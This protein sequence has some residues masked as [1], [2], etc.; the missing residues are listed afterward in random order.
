MRTRKNRHWSAAIAM[1]V[2]LAAGCFN[3]SK[4]SLFDI[5]YLYN[6]ERDF[7]DLKCQVY[8][9]TDTTSVAFVS[10]SL[11]DLAYE[12]PPYGGQ[13]QAQYEISYRLMAS[14]ESRDIL[15]SVTYRYADS[16]NFGKEVEIIHDLNIPAEFGQNYILAVELRDVFRKEEI[17]DFIPVYKSNRNNQQNFLALTRARRPLFRSYLREEEQVKIRVNDRSHRYLF[18]R[19]YFRDFP[20]ARP[21]FVQER[22]TS[23]NYGADSTFVLGIFDGETNYF[24]LPREGFYHFQTDTV[25]KQGFTLYRFYEGFPALIT[26]EHLREP[27]RY[28]T[29]KKEYDE[30][31]AGGDRKAAVDNFWL[32]SAGNE[33]RARNLIQKYYSGV[34]EANEFFTSYLEGWRTDRGMIYIIFGKPDVVYRGLQQE[35]W[36][37]GEPEHRNSLRFTFVQVQNPFSYNDYMLLRSAT[38]KDPWYMK[39]QT[40]RR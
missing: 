40:W 1:I 21:P 13:Y 12:R 37:Y 14:Y 30:I 23:F 16:A 34:Q 31:M 24:D 3:P 7:T 9:V 28:I 15:D 35:E 2:I 36:I 20:V 4:I 11:S 18:V 27:L 38:L 26:A 19:A 25:S 17:K 39:V 8:H 5:S 32:S 33:L 6:S 29:T 10:V 22:K